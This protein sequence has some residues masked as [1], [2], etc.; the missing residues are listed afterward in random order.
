M[1]SSFNDWSRLVTKHVL[2]DPAGFSEL[3]NRLEVCEH[4]GSKSAA[5]AM[6]FLLGK[7]GSIPEKEEPSVYDDVVDVLDQMGWRSDGK[8]LE[9]CEAADKIFGIIYQWIDKTLEEDGYPEAEE[10]TEAEWNTRKVI[11]EAFANK[12]PPL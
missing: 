5:A 3:V 7:A 1:P 6:G 12:M 8:G 11:M 2:D 9:A 4:A 10:M